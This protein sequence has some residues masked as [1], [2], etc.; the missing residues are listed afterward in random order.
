VR[1]RLAP[2]KRKVQMMWQQKQ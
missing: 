2:G 1:F